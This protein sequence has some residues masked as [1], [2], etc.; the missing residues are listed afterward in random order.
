MCSLLS[1]LQMKTLDEISD[2]CKRELQTAI[3]Q[4]RSASSG[5][6]GQDPSGGLP[7]NRVPGDSTNTIIGVVGFLVVLAVGG[8]STCWYFYKDWEREVGS[9]P[10]RKY[11]PNK[12]KKTKF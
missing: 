7:S 9:R 6:D 8:M 12:P 11:K 1:V 4:M 10:K 3:G 5:G 2:E